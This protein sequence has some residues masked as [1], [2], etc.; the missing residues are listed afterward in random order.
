MGTP[1]ALIRKALRR[2]AGSCEP[3]SSITSGWR[4]A[5]LASRASRSHRASCE[6]CDDGARAWAVS[7][8]CQGVF[9]CGIASSKESA[10]ERL[11]SG[12]YDGANCEVVPVVIISGKPFIDRPWCA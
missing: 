2:K 8:D 6:H 12:D 1:S 3:A 5:S 9:T 11:N 7:N 4:K 10:T